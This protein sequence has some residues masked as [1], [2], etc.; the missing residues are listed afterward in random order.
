MVKP[1]G[2]AS[3]MRSGA[4]TRRATTTAAWWV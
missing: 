3:L 2:R 1:V 4:C